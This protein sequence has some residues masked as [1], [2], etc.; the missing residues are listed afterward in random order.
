MNIGKSRST[1]NQSSQPGAF[2]GRSVLQRKCACGNKAPGGGE[3]GACA[4]KKPVI[5]RRESSGGET[6]GTEPASVTGSGRALSKNLQNLFRPS[7]GSLIDRVRI[8]DNGSSANFTASQGAVAV[9]SGANIY[10]GNDA[11][12]T[13][14]ASGRKLLAHELAHVHQQHR[15]NG[16]PAGY[17][18]TPGDAYEREADHFAETGRLPASGVTGTRT[19]AP[20]Y[21]ARTAIEQIASILRSAVQGLGTD[22]DAIFNALTGRTPAEINAIKAAYRRLSGGETLEARLRDELSGRDLSRALSL[23][24]GETA[25]T[26]TARRLWDAMRGLGTDESAIYSA[27]A[28]KTAAQ[29]NDVQTAYRSLRGNAL[30]TDLREELNDREWQYLQTLLP[31]AAGGAVTGADRAT[32]IANRLEAAMA[33]LGT[34]EDA[35][36][37]ALTGRS[38]A[39]LRA[40]ETRFRLLTG[41]ALDVRLRDELNDAEYT[42][43]QR[44]LH[45]LLDPQRIAVRLRHAV[46][47]IGTGELEIQAVLTGRTPAEL[48]LINAAYQAMYGE[49]LRDRLNAE[50][51]GAERSATET[52]RQQGVLPLED[53][54]KLSIEGAGT[55]E[56][57]LFA[58]LTE[59]QND[60]NPGLRLQ[61]VIDAYAAK[62]YGV[63]LEDIRR[64]LTG[65]EYAQALGSLLGHIPTAGCSNQQRDTGRAAIAG[66]ASLAQKAIALLNADIGRG[67]LSS[68]V[69]S[70]LR[71]NFNPGNTPG[72]VN[73]G[74]ATQVRDVFVPAR[75]DLYRTASIACTTPVPFPAACAGPDPCAAVP[76]CTTFTSAWTCGA[77]G[78]GAVVRLCAAFFQCDSDKSGTML[79]EFIHHFGVSDKFYRHQSGFSTLV[80]AGNGSATDSLDN[81][82]SFSEFAKAVS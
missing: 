57:R 46:E 44:L 1:A 19:A 77:A 27:V 31:G 29:W 4:K 55:D 2:P 66:A 20:A 8:H 54:I 14:T 34:D 70:A 62:G 42:R 3:C 52:L 68:R 80:P 51:S 67:A 37:A 47:R 60:P 6:A 24:G 16:P 76:N 32:V 45:P 58:A 25:A 13:G 17:R 50:L 36:Y 5:Q 65:S 30:L 26:E 56:E 41:F 53:E 9:T 22:E 82:D 33:G 63:M 74:L 12:Q 69:R 18:S 48:A 78:P 35:I 64:D 59:I 28:G 40:I 21:Q 39:E 10:F 49:S 43:A 73:V 81:A 75:V 15:D 71:A 11:F 23:L 38:N 79:H 72:A 7:L 61:T